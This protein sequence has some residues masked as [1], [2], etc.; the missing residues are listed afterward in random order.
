M[1]KTHI[2]QVTVNNE[3]NFLLRLCVGQFGRGN[4]MCYLAYQFYLFLTC[5]KNHKYLMKENTYFITIHFVNHMGGGTMGVYTPGRPAFIAQTKQ[6][7]S[8]IVG[9]TAL[10][11]AFFMGY[12]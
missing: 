9:L 5:I 7:V 3:R 4:C 10:Q 2:D 11:L 12:E 1:S 8:N 6:K